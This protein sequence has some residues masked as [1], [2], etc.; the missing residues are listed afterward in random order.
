MGQSDPQ[1]M[2]TKPVCFEA[3]LHYAHSLL[4]LYGMRPDA[5]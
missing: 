4:R 5:C 2:P 1:S 3:A